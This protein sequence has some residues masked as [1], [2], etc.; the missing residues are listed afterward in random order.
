[1][2]CT[3]ELV[4]GSNSHEIKSIGRLVISYVLSML[5]SAHDKK[6]QQQQ[7]QIIAFSK[8]RGYR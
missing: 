3:S 6:K 8:V 5:S 4:K 2:V 7:Q 1:M